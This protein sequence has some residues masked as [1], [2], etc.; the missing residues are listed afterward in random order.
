MKDWWFGQALE[1][2]IVKV[3]NTGYFN[4]FFGAAVHKIIWYQVMV[5]TICEP[6]R[7]DG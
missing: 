6:F 7:Q 4:M 3:E 2:E 1:G 5:Q